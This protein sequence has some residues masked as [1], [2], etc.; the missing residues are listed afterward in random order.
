MLEQVLYQ[1]RQQ[2]REQEVLYSRN[3]LESLSVVVLYTGPII[4]ITPTGFI[5][6][7]KDLGLKKEG[8]KDVHETYR[9]DDLGN[10]LDHHLTFTT[11]DNFKKRVK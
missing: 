11:L 4:R 8:I 7:L 3:D 5:V 2:A 10:I 9:L 1:P 6:S